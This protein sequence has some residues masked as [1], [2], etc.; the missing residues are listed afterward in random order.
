MRKVSEFIQDKD[1]PEIS[2]LQESVVSVDR[3]KTSILIEQEMCFEGYPINM[4][5]MHMFS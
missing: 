5:R 3:N 4:T 2:W 1:N